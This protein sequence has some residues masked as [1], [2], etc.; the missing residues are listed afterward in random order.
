MDE[1]HLPLS[2]PPIGFLIFLCE[3]CPKYPPGGG[4]RHSLP[5]NP[6]IVCFCVSGR[7]FSFSEMTDPAAHDLGPNRWAERSAH[8]VQG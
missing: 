6:F 1:R 8:M 3:T 4:E 7:L 5:P 2:I